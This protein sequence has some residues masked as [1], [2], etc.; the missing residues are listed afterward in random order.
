MRFRFAALLGLSALVGFCVLGESAPLLSGAGMPQV[1]LSEPIGEA[2][3]VDAKPRVDLHIVNGFSADEE[4]SIIAAVVDWNR[5]GPVHLDV[6]ALNYDAIEPGAW[7]ISKADGGNTSPPI[8]AHAI[9]AESGSIV[10][11]V[12]R[13]ADGELRRVVAQEFAKVF[14]SPLLAHSPTDKAITR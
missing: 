13:L 1:L 2:A 11:K 6:A 8:V 3:P 7:S 4:A 10:V 14:G 5:I 12:G 9:S